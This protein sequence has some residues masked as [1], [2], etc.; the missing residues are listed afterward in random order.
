MPRF[1]LINEQTRCARHLTQQEI[2]NLVDVRTNPGGYTNVERCLAMIMNPA[3]GQGYMSFPLTYRGVQH[4]I[5]VEGRLDV[6]SR[7]P[8]RYRPPD[9]ECS[10]KC[11]VEAQ[12]PAKERRIIE[13][14]NR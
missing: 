11:V 10:A 6:A 4:S 3:P 2:V 9:H 5:N 12:I 8:L 1:I 7:K 14:V 13:R